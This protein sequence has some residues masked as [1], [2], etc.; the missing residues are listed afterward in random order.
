MG[1][2]RVSAEP[3]G[4]GAAE[5]TFRVYLELRSEEGEQFFAADGT[6]GCPEAGGSFSGLAACTFLENFVE[7]IKKK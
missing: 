1:Y 2:Q 7:V 6:L 4:E 3:S 5:E